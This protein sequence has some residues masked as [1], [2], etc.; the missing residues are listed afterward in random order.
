M[1]RISLLVLLVILISSGCQ[2]LPPTITPTPT[3]TPTPSPTPLPTP[4]PFVVDLSQGPDALGPIALLFL[5]YYPEDPR[6][7]TGWQ[8]FG[9]PQAVALGAKPWGPAQE[10]IT[11]RISSGITPS[12]YIG[13]AH[14]Q[15]P[16]N[17]YTEIDH[18]PTYRPN[19]YGFPHE[20]G[21]FFIAAPSD[22]HT[23]VHHC[24]DNNLPLPLRYPPSW[25]LCVSE[26]NL[27]IRYTSHVIARIEAPGMASYPVYSPDDQ[28]IAFHLQRGDQTQIYLTQPDGTQTHPLLELDASSSISSQ[29]QLWPAWSNDSQ[30]L[31]LTINHHLYI[32]DLDGSHLTQIATQFSG[33][34]SHPVWS[35]DENWIAFVSH[36][37][38]TFF[39]LYIASTLTPR[40]IHIGQDHAGA[41]AWSP[42]SQWLAYESYRHGNWDIFVANIENPLWENQLTSDTHHDRMPQWVTD[43]QDLGY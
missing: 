1:A 31:A 5:R 20:L 28:W 35:P 15:L 19:F 29:T 12:I 38:G 42:N 14:P 7:P 30:R 6:S 24:Q 3:V 9:F 4:T 32:V 36:A 21:L 8:I 18:N 25:Q 26:S 27:P 40:V 39:D 37:D 10:G 41:P 13:I 23:F 34:I 43:N 11:N 22:R 33:P 16:Q 2:L 17:P